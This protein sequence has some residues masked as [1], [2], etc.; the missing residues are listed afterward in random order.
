MNDGTPENPSAINPTGES[1]PAGIPPASAT[2]LSV[3]EQALAQHNASSAKP[4]R[5]RGRP[6]EHGKYSKARQPGVPVGTVDNSTQPILLEETPAPV[7]GAPGAAG[8][9]IGTEDIE[10]PFDEAVN[11]QYASLIVSGLVGISNSVKRSRIIKRTGNEDLAEFVICEKK[12]GEE[13]KVAMETGLIGMARKYGVD[14]SKT[15]EGIFIGGLLLWQTEERASTAA[16]IAKY[17]KL[18]PQEA[19]L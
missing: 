12:L 11:R 2:T 3:G 10:K 6:I 18:R 8:V 19:K 17:Q 14:L 4:K 9:E 7:N 13:P 15:P 1:P 16:L 5:T